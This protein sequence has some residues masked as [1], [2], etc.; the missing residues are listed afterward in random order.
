MEVHISD[1]EGSVTAVFLGRRKIGGI[2]AGRKLI[3]EGL[4]IADG[5]RLMMYN[6]MYELI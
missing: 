5:K 3:V 1:G 2:V 4:T 6:P